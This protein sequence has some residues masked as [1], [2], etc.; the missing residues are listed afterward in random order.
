VFRWEVLALLMAGLLLFLGVQLWRRIRDVD[1]LQRCVSAYE[2]VHTAV[3]SGLVDRMPVRWPDR[4]ART[5]CGAL[6]SAGRLERLPRRGG[7]GLLP[8]RPQS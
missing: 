2:N 6:Q 3:D 7:P 1:S 4:S 8:P 5:T